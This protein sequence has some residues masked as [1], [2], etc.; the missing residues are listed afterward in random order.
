M[1]FK[2]MLDKTIIISNY[3]GACCLSMYM[4]GKIINCRE[5][6]D[7]KIEEITDLFYNYKDDEAIEKIGNLFNP[8]MII[9]CENGSITIIDW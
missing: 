2:K 7:K 3:D 5:S 8:E 4:N 1:K 9:Y 6:E